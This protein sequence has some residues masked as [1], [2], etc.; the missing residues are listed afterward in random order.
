MISR[1]LLDEIPDNIE[2]VFEG[3]NLHLL[4]HRSKDFTTRCSCPDQ[5]NPCKH[6]AGVYYLIAAQ[7]DLDPF[8]LFEL[9]G[10]SRVKLR[11]ELAKSPLGKILS[12]SLV[13]RKIPLEPAR[14]YH[15]R[16]L[17]VEAPHPVNLKHF[18]LGGQRLPPL[19]ERDREASIPALPIKKAGDFPP[20]WSKDT[21]FLSAMEDLYQR[22]R[23]KHFGKK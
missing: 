3:M 20:F 5:E 19:P 14:S 11:E 17:K 21:S 23:V 9:R 8:L 12:E 6:I 16:P 10:I 13:E 1:L 22:V 2:S 4:P 18:W 15:T 7:L